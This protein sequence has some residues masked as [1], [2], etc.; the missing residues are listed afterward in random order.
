MKEI[1]QQ[2]LQYFTGIPNTFIP[3]G[4]IAESLG[5]SDKAIR[6]HLPAVQDYLNDQGQLGVIE[7]KAGRGVRL[8]ITEADNTRLMDRLHHSFPHSEGRDRSLRTTMAFD[9]L[10]A[11]KPIT[12]QK[13]RKDYYLSHSAVRGLLDEVEAWLEPFGLDMIRKQKIGVYISGEEKQ[14]RQA[15]TG[16]SSLNEGSSSVTEALFDS[17]FIRTI[18][19]ELAALQEK[20]D[21]D[22]TDASLESLLLHTAFMIKR[23]QLGQIISLPEEDVRSLQA[24]E[25]LPWAEEMCERLERVFAMTFPKE[26]IL[27]LTIHLRSA[28]THHASRSTLTAELPGEISEMID[29]LIKEAAR[30]TGYR[31]AEDAVLRDHLYVHLKTTLARLSYG[32]SISNPL[33]RTIKKKYPY[34]FDTLVWII[35]QHKEELLY[36]IPEEEVGYLVLHFQ[37]ALE[38]QATVKKEKVE[39]VIVCHMGM[40][41][42]QLLAAR[43]EKLFPDIHIHGSI[44]AHRLRSF[45]KEHPVDGIISTVPVQEQGVPTAVVS[46]LFET[47]DQSLVKRLIKRLQQGK[48]QGGMKEKESLLLQHMSPF[49]FQTGL[50]GSSKYEVIEELSS[51]LVKKGYVKEGYP[52]SCLHREYLSS[53]AIGGGIAIPHGQAEGVN[54]SAI[55]AAV[56]SEPLEWSGE[57][58]HVVLLLAMK[59]EN[60]QEAR[61]LFREIHTLTTDPAFVKQLAGQKDGVSFMNALNNN[62]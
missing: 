4:K 6:N 44:A 15:V 18:R 25:E 53:T 29:W 14:I 38:R 22:F 62:P 52:A 19:H 8:A 37:A 20:H 42:S 26:E 39:V 11:S 36:P 49:L 27:Y 10:S 9:L 41:L 33:L 3:T 1:Q 16:L 24:H 5:Y 43:M 30:Q 55:A 2:I 31:F 7:K 13:L 23:V 47:E 54:S 17:F 60:T 45:T 21:V 46:P 51:M 56:F 59:Y 32:L 48:D 58:V 40:G 50:S 12:I 61:Q 34:L 57:P 35:D 28:K